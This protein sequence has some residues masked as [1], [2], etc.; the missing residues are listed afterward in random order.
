MKRHEHALGVQQGIASVSVIARVLSEAAAEAA[1][2]GIGAERDAA[3]RVIV[4]RLAG[5]CR[6]DEISY[7]YDAVTLADTYCTLMNECKARA[8]ERDTGQAELPVR[9]LRP[10]APQGRLACHPDRRV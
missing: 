5:L 3:V 9:K 10:D 8:L 2:E 6:V 4:H 7:G 1:G